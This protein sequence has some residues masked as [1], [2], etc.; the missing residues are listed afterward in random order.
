MK[1]VTVALNST[2]RNPHIIDFE[3][4]SVSTDL[5]ENKFPLYIYEEDRLN[6]RPVPQ[7]VIQFFAKGC[8]WSNTV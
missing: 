4:E 2:Q 6:L 8:S 7:N 3:L 1:N 5:G